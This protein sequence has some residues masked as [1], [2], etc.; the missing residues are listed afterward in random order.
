MQKVYKVLKYMQVFRGRRISDVRNPLIKHGVKDGAQLVLLK[1]RTRPQEST[2]TDTHVAPNLEDV[3]RVIRAE[4]GRQGREVAQA[5]A[6]PPRPR[7]VPMEARLHDIMQ[8]CSYM[9][10]IFIIQ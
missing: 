7:E 5:S 4:A 9:L 6:A 3:E 10:R 1:L 8:A 2:P